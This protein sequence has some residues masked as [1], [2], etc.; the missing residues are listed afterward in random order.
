MIAQ[1]RT[2]TNKSNK[3]ICLGIILA[4]TKDCNFLVSNNIL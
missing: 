2:E 3:E 1:V 4:P